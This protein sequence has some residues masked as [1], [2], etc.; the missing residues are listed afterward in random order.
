MKLYLVGAVALILIGGGAYYWF[1]IA[2]APAYAT[3]T[4]QR[5]SILQEVLASGN[6]EAPTTINLQFQNGGKLVAIGV[7]TGD[8]VT[9]GETLARQDS[10]VLGAQLQQAQAAV[11]GQEAELEVLV[12]GTRPEQ[13]AVTQSQIASDQ[14]ALAQA[15]QSVVNAIQTAYTQSY[16]AV[17][18]KADQFFNSPHGGTPRISFFASDS[19]IISTLEAERASIDIVLS[20]WQKNNAA[21]DPSADLSSAVAG[22]QTDLSAVAQFLSD[23]NAALN[24][25]IPSGQTTQAVIDAWISNIAIA[26]ANVNAAVSG[27]TVALT[28]QKNAASALDRDRKTLAL[29]QAGSTGSAIAAQEARVAQA[30]ANV[31]AIRA[32]ITQ[33]TLLAPV[34]GTV[35]DVTGE[36]G[37][38]ISPAGAVV[39][40]I[41]AAELQVGVNLSEDNVGGVRV[42][43]K[44]SISLDAFPD[45]AWQGTVTKVDPAQT[46]IGGA[47]YYK[48]KVAFS[49]PDDRVKP[50]MTANVLIETGTASSTLIVPASAIQKDGART[51]VRVYENDTVTSKDVTTGLKSRGGAI[52]VGSGLS[53]GEHV[54]VGK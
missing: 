1:R 28:A 23:S 10:A 41:P 52:E 29:E 34:G 39:P 5:G 4:V 25:A 21:L 45:A 49:E 9:A 42:G 14:A 26:R 8:T 53:A 17:H 32:Q 16:D 33:T 36:I 19:Q 48:T 47:V 27:I 11:A 20:A 6:V 2:S 24:R 12:R 43:Q 18:N 30:K 3:A 15:S 40:M 35:T 7:Q 22:A 37:E 38:R 46:I 44:V 31:A 51:F 13:I 54:V 50:G